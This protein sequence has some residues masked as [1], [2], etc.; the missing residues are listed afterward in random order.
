[1]PEFPRTFSR[2]D[3]VKA[4]LSNVLKLSDAADGYQLAIRSNREFS[5]NVLYTPSTMY[6]VLDPAPSSVLKLAVDWS[7]IK[8]SA[9]YRRV[10]SVLA[11]K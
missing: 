2:P 11:G 7:A 4:L 10:Q 8:V 1:M 5:G 3:H 6:A 9:L